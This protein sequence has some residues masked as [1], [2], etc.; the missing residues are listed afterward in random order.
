MNI[1]P[2]PSHSASVSKPTDIQTLQETFAAALRR[3]G[4]ENNGTQADSLLEILRP[5]PADNAAGQD[6]NQQRRET[7][8]QTDKNDFTQIDRKFLN[9]SELRSGEMRADYQNR[10][11]R[12]ESHQ[13]NHQE[14]AERKKIQQSP[15]TQ[16]TSAAVPLDT[17]RPSE[18]LPNWNSPPQRDTSQV[19][20]SE[21]AAANNQ[22]SS[23]TVAAPNSPA[24]A[25]QAGVLMPVKLTMSV[26]STP[27]TAPQP[28]TAQTFTVFTPSGQFR[29]QDKSN[30]DE[31]EK[32]E[33]E[34]AEEKP[35]KMQPFAVLEAFR[36]ET[37]RPIQKS[38]HQNRQPRQPME[39]TGQSAPQQLGNTSWQTSQHRPKEVEPERTSSVNTLNELLNTSPQN[40][41]AQKEEPD[42][43]NQTQYLNRIAAACEAAGQFA[44]IRIK[45]NLDHLGTLTLRFFYKAEKLALRFETPS[46]ETALFL[47]DNLEELCTLLSKKNVETIDV[48]I[49]WEE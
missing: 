22:Y 42:S 15:P 10:L 44:P 16:L 47:R 11:D 20:V 40:I 34:Q 38:Q 36:A 6:R 30:K 9:K 7:Q 1:L 45:I 24:T 23:V 28:A 17:A 25:G 8:Q 39:S 13:Y 35:V 37:T 3:Y 2:Y 27:L 29:R 4:T 21:V 49:A 48:E 5:A 12:Q 26:A 43:P 46:R 32:E 19:N 18:S 41:T 14:R 31:E 33:S